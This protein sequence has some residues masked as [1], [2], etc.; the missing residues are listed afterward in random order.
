MPTQLEI[1]RHLDMSE[2]NARDVLKALGIDWQSSSLDDIRIAYI[3]DLR[4]K[5][6]G[7]GGEDQQTL[8]KARAQE[9]EVNARLKELQYQREIGKLILGE[10]IEPMLATWAATA[11]SEVGFAVEKLIAGIVSQHGIE[12]DQDVID[13]ALSAAYDAISDY[14]EKFTSDDGEDWPSMA[15][16]AESASVAMDGNGVSTA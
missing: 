6:A 15:S 10:E 8:T 4:E 12:V 5:A 11:R 16:S 13:D 7:R 9:A 1:A 2:R 3:R 14:P